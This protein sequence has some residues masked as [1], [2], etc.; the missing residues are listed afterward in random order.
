MR[1]F[2][3]TALSAA[4]TSIA[5]SGCSPVV[6]HREKPTQII[7]TI[8]MDVTVE[9]QE[10][11]FN[12]QVVPAELTPLAFLRHGE[13][14]KIAVA[15]GQLVKQGQVIAILDDDTAQEQ[16]ADANAR[17]QLAARQLSRGRELKQ[18]NMVSEAELD[19][20]SA[21]YKLAMANLNLAKNQVNYTKLRAPFDGMVS[22]VFKQ[23]FEQVNVG[24][25]VVSLYDPTLVYVEI[26]IPD[27]ILARTQTGTAKRSTYRPDAQ[28]AGDSATYQLSYLEHT[29]ELHSSSQS[30][31]MWLTMPQPEK[32]IVPGTSVSIAVDL[33]QA[34]LDY[35]SG[36]VV[37]MTAI[38]ADQ[39]SFYVWRVEDSAV[40]RTPVQVD[41]V[42]HKG[43]VVT[44][45]LNLGD[46]IAN[47]NLRKLREGMIIK[48]AQQ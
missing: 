29:S 11:I 30:Y 2:K 47:S 23:D 9:G 17:M 5:L 33:N 44:H 22:E 32:T 4:M 13:I 8:S 46:T 24:E 34:G 12:G 16:L 15:E 20:L 41:R 1:L 21:N 18:S 39:H 43:A 19:E 27:A 7:E 25:P 26:T 28:F 35:S 6:E 31:Q 3:L 38:D 40:F 37:P 10:R 14:K 36:F 42:D 45:G 48:G